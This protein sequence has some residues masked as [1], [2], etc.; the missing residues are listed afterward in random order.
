M[1]D[2]DR[3]ST[4]IERWR[5]S[6]DFQLF[7]MAVFWQTTPTVRASKFLVQDEC[8]PASHN[9]FQ[10]RKVLAAVLHP[11]LDLTAKYAQPGSFSPDDTGGPL[12]F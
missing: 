4:A 6:L 2:L 12:G 3:M 1:R 8:P 10:N 5:L 11:D 7:P 9:Y